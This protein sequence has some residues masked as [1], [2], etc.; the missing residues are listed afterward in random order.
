MNKATLFLSI[1]L[2]LALA[3]MGG[4]I[5]QNEQD[6]DLIMQKLSATPT[7]TPNEIPSTFDGTEIESVTPTPTATNSAQSTGTL[8]G[9]LS[10]PSEQFPAKMEVCAEDTTSKAE[11][12]TSELLKE[13]GYMYGV[14]YK[15]D[16]PAGTY[17]IYAKLPND[18][19]KAYYSKFVVCGLKAECAD[20]S[21]VPISVT[22]N[23][24]KPKIDPQDW[25]NK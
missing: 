12:C 22:A 21:P 23:S 3:A 7:V 6:K 19:Y 2:L 10:F 11:I 9:S 4:Y 16:V 1:V 15:L 5:Y 25:Y 17:T 18:P 14:G 24:T 13:T 8:T 20:H